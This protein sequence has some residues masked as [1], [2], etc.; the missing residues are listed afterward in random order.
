[1]TINLSAAFN[2]NEDFFLG[3][4][5]RQQVPTHLVSPR[6]PSGSQRYYGPGIGYAAAMLL[7]GQVQVEQSG[8]TLR[9]RFPSSGKAGGLK[10]VASTDMGAGRLWSG[11]SL[12]S[13]S[14]PW[15]LA[16]TEAVVLGQHPETLAALRTLAGLTGAPVAIA[17]LKPLPSADVS[18]REALLRLS[19]H[20]YYELKAKLD[21][22]EITKGAVNLSGLQP[23]P[24][25]ALMKQLL[26][27]RETPTAAA[28]SP[29][30]GCAA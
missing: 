28:S 26:G 9:I 11:D 21:A 24:P 19:D 25:S 27:T 29:W 10:T 8:R 5:R 6:G 2:K 20:A 17:A 13:A 18:V 3:L 16:L 14:A 7:T 4:I 23:V 12:D 1:M 15:V 30:P 22:S